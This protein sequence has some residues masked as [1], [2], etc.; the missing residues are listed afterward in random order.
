MRKSSKL[1]F[2]HSD[3]N[4]NVV[5]V[6]VEKKGAKPTDKK[7][8]SDNSFSVRTVSMAMIKELRASYSK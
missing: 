5:R 3:R 4:K 7:S 8:R 1:S 6:H 2:T